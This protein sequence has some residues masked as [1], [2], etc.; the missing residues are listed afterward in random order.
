MVGNLARLH[1]TYVTV[2]GNTTEEGAASLVSELERCG[3]IVFE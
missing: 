3:L 2:T 1:E